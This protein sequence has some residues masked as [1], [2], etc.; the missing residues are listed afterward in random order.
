[1][2]LSLPL[3]ALVTVDKT[4][5]VNS[6]LTLTMLERAMSVCRDSGLNG[7]RGRNT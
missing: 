6:C 4:H 7:L 1:M 3:T 2:I 5:F